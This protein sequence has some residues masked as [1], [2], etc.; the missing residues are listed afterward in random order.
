MQISKNVNNEV[1]MN[2]PILNIFLTLNG[3]FFP[4]V[5]FS[6]VR[7]IS[8]SLTEPVCEFVTRFVR[9]HEG[10]VIGSVDYCFGRKVNGSEDEWR[11]GRDDRRLTELSL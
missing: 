7:G 11:R 3:A 8:F 10:S 9:A 5:S 4:T 6:F 2:P 1:S